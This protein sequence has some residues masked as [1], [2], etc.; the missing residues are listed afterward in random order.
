MR[1]L[2]P[3][4]SLAFGHPPA[5]VPLAGLSGPAGDAIRLMAARGHAHAASFFA[6]FG[7][8]DPILIRTAWRVLDAGEGDVFLDVTMGNRPFRA[9]RRL[10]RRAEAMPPAPQTEDR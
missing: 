7:L 8:P 10:R 1:P 3:L 5:P 9:P 6:A 2:N 4:P